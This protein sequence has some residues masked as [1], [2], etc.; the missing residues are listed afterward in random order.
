MQSYFQTFM[1]PLI[2]ICNLDMFHGRISWKIKRT[3][4]RNFEKN[5]R[6]VTSEIG[7]YC[8]DMITNVSSL[9]SPQLPTLL[10]Y[11]KFR[12]QTYPLEMHGDNP[13]G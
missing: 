12:S 6:T 13:S 11:Q 9:K 4:F 2:L 1:V 7:E 3:F 10:S 8:N 5:K